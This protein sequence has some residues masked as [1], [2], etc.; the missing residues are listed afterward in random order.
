MILCAAPLLSPH[1]HSSGPEGS[2]SA[3]DADSRTDEREAMVRDQ[4]ADRGVKDALVLRAV[5]KVPR[6]LFVPSALADEAYRDRPV[7]IGLGQTISQPYIVAMMTEL[8]RLKGDGGEKVLEIGTGSGYQAAVLAEIAGEVH[9]VEILKALYDRVRDL[10]ARLGYAGLFIHC[11][12]GYDGLPEF[13]PYDAIIL[14]AAPMEI[15]PPL[16]ERLKPGGRLVAPVGAVKQDLVVY[17]RTEAGL[18][19]ETVFGVRFVP[20]TGR[21]AEGRR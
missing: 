10:P 18:K 7:S 19:K 17:T 12:D 16:F 1:S 2:G 20:M 6:H 21:V 13:A 14:T 5:R 9:S 15:P 8:L 3:A 4:I 11:G